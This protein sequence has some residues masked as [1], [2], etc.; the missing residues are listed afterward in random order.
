MANLREQ[1]KAVMIADLKSTIDAEVNLGVNKCA[2]FL[3]ELEGM[4]RIS[5]FMMVAVIDPV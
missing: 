3:D 1:Y 2:I 5:V 4:A